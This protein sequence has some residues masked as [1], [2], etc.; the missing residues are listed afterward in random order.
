M[1][2]LDHLLLGLIQHGDCSGYDSRKVLTATPMKRYSDSPG[3]IYPAL[4]RLERLK[5]IG[6]IA[7]RASARGRTLYRLTPKGRAVLEAWLR[8]PVTEDE[9]ANRL[10]DAMLR[11]SVQHLAGDEA[12]A[13]RFVASI[14][15]AARSH[16]EKL[17][18]YIAKSTAGFP[19]GARLALESGLNTYDS[20]A[21]WAEARS[22]PPRKKR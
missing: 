5:L 3:S 18:T 15:V 6:S 2:R 16:A 4:G 17:R 12:A 10:E 22:N 21:R 11:L 20:L 13:H 1:N 19:A 8:R 14:A 9:I 7:D